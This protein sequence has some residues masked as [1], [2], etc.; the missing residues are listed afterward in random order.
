MAPQFVIK[1]NMRPFVNQDTS[2]KMTASLTL[3]GTWLYQGRPSWMESRNSTELHY[4]R[5]WQFHLYSLWTLIAFTQP[6]VVPQVAMGS[7]E[8]T[9]SFSKMTSGKGLTSEEA[10]PL[11]TGIC[12]RAQICFFIME[13]SAN[14]T[15]LLGCF[16]HDLKHTGLLS[17]A[18]TILGESDSWDYESLFI[19]EPT[20]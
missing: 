3:G 10:T 13:A 19:G 9:T 1:V 8:R 18:I 5:L 15:R 14:V 2:A 7:G 20:M 11:A 12:Q 17:R 16:L 6:Q 4:L